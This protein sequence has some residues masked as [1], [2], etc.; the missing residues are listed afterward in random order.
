MAGMTLP[1]TYIDVRSEGL[2]SPGQVTVGNLGVVGTAAKGPIG[3]PQLL[4]SL[5]DAQ[6]TFGAYDSWIDPGTLAKRAGELTLTRALELVFGFGGS[7]VYAV[8]VAN[9]ATK[10]TYAVPTATAGQG[11]L[12]TAKTPGTWANDDLGVNVAAATDDAYVQDETFTGPTDTL[13]HPPKASARNRLTIFSGGISHS[14]TIVYDVATPLP[15]VVSIATTG[16]ST[17]QITYSAGEA[18]GATDTV[19]VSYVVPAANAH[20]VT[21]QSGHLQETYTVVNNKDLARQLSASA[22][23]DATVG[24]AL[25][26]LPTLTPLTLPPSFASFS[27]GGNGVSGADYGAGLIPLLTQPAH[28]IVLAGQDDSLGHKL[29]AHCQKASGDEIKGD[30]IGIV[31]SSALNQANLEASF[32]GII[33]HS[34]DSDRIIFVAPGMRATDTPTGDEV[35]LTGAYT[36]AAFAGL[37]SSFSPQ[38]SPTN[39]NLPV[40]ELETHFDSAHLKALLANRVLTIESRQGFRIVRGI[41]TSTGSAFAQITT[42]RIIDYA[43]FGVRSAANPFVG[44]LN[45]ERVRGA[46]RASIS[47]FLGNMVDDEMLESYD[48]SVTATRAQEIQGI[49]DVTLVLRPVFSIDYIKVTMIL[50]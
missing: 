18:P 15:G 37:L 17:G 1:G 35:T 38:V 16:A 48:V 11:V 5:A 49:V 24:S 8:R 39:K 30:R 12:L 34:L 4:G 46:L 14:R 43:K 50:Q 22:W 3:V 21:L 40:D 41:T 20:L 23:V 19:K 25:T 42:R 47:M 44:L 29:D 31:G 36:A 33:G 32:D 13:V 28:I 9:G 26:E 27:G 2:I 45:N 7:V 6:A 10:A